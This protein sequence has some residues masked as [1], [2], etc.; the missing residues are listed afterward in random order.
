MRLQVNYKDSITQKCLGKKAIT[1]NEPSSLIKLSFMSPPNQN[2]NHWII[3][4]KT[5]PFI[6]STHLMKNIYDSSH[7]H[8]TDNFKQEITSLVPK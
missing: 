6:Y 3:S 7:P 2:L 1:N 5:Y 8:S 4:V